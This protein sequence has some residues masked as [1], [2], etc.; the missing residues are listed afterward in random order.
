MGS[1]ANQNDLKTMAQINPQRLFTA[2]RVAIGSTATAFVVIGAIMA[3]LKEYFVLTNE[4]VGWIGGAALWGFII[5]IL[6]FGSLCDVFGMK[7][8]VRLGAIGHISGALVMIFANGFGMLFCGALMLS[9]S[10]GLVQAACNPLVATIYSE[11][12]TEMINKLHL[13]FPGGIVIGG[14][15]TF[16]LDK[17]SIGFWQ[18]KLTII[19][20]PAVVYGLL[21]L[22]QRFPVTERVQSG[23]S[24][25]QMFKDTLLRPLF[26]LLLVC[27]MMT[28]SLE[29]GPSRWIPAVL[30]SAGISGIL[31]LVW[32]SGLMAVLRYFA[33][34][35]LHRL[36]PMGILFFSAVVAG[37][38]LLWLSY[39]Q[40][41]VTAIAAGS[42]FAVGVA[43]F[44]PT[45]TGVTSERV[46]KGGA[47]ALAL[48]TGT[49]ML[50]AGLIT[51][52]TM[53]WVTDRY[54]HEKLPLQQTTACLRKI[55]DTYPALVTQA[56]GKTAGDIKR[57]VEDAQKVIDAKTIDAA[58]PRIATA[59]ALR[60][61]IASAPKSEA[62]KTAKELLGPA[63]NYA[64]K[65]SFRRLAPLSIVLA[66]I[67]GALYLRDRARGG[68]IAEKITNKS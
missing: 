21:F 9:M 31:V 29:L 16:V 50:A 54:L 52:P 39:V 22:R 59:N 35:V 62:A 2:S 68:Y 42:V 14:L 32:I 65:I 61:A 47:L 8:L 36:S 27:M 4:Q 67:F 64:G 37:V 33:G 5:T 46:P 40:T 66:F 63:E 15:I 20:V 12:K 18:L 3:S 53:G 26:L 24:F 7:L 41:L 17:M 48:M 34:P 43:Y 23:I 1:E 60:I 11:R 30:Q 6:I 45:M 55:I 44:W 56:K 10:D 49:G 51:L 13:W 25:G 38:G 19:M 58:L 28:A 57:A